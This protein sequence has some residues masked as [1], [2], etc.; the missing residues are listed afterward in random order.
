MHRWRLPETRTEALEL[1]LEPYGD[2]LLVPSA[3]QFASCPTTG[4]TIAAQSASAVTNPQNAHGL[5]SSIGTQ[6][7]WHAW[8]DA[9]PFALADLMRSATFACFRLGSEQQ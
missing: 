2:K 7:P 3:H 1:A 5:A 6:C 8:V 9:G 4:D